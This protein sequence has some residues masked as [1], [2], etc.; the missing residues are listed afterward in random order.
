M[1]LYHTFSFWSVINQSS[2][3]HPETNRLSNSLVTS[4]R[5]IPNKMSSIHQGRITKAQGKPKPVSQRRSSARQQNQL[6]QTEADDNEQKGMFDAFLY[7]CW[8]VILL[9]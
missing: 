8:I 6:K 7:Q 3:I 1:A 4:T 2:N 5:F 9:H